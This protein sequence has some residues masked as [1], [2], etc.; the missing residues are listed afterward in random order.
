MAGAR[1][2]HV[3]LPRQ[4][5]VSQ[6]PG[7]SSPSTPAQSN[8][9]TVHYSTVLPELA[10]HLLLYV[11]TLLLAVVVLL[12]QAPASVV[13]RAPNT[14]PVTSGNQIV[15]LLLLRRPPSPPRL[16]LF[17]PE[18]NFAFA[19]SLQKKSQLVSSYAVANLRSST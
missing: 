8:V 15:L 4:L 19:L 11:C 5:A 10:R 6:P 7:E 12:Q 14:G 1:G 17:F 3:L 18:V 16:Q 9:C 13:R 2:K